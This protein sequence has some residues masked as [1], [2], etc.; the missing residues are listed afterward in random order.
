VDEKM[1]PRMEM[2]GIE[3]GDRDWMMN[4]PYTMTTRGMRDALLRKY[5]LNKIFGRHHLGG[6]DTDELMTENTR[7]H[8][9]NP[10]VARLYGVDR[11]NR[12]TNVGEEG[13]M[14][15]RM[16]DRLNLDDE[17]IRGEDRM[18]NGGRR[19]DTID[20]MMNGGRRFDTIDRMMNGGRRF[21]TV[22][23]MMM[24]GG[25]VDTVDRM[26]MN[27]GRVNTVD[28]MMMTPLERVKMMNGMN[29]RTNVEDDIMV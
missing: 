14:G 28:R 22:D 20:R 2:D 3:S 4:T 23:R 10:L 27:G 25:R 9:M 29:A 13:I 11:M 12:M 21:D 8:R 6:F 17:L 18:M 24:N 15:N 5:F 26:M 7:M 16:I 19:F 1:M